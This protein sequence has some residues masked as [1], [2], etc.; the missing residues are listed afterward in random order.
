MKSIINQKYFSTA[1]EIMGNKSY[2]VVFKIS[3]EGIDLE[4]SSD[5]NVEV[6]IIKIPKK[7]FIKYEVEKDEAFS[8]DSK[9]ILSII[10]KYPDENIDMTTDES[11]INLIITKNRR[12]REYNRR[13]M[14]VK[15]EKDAIVENVKEKLKTMKFDN[16]LKIKTKELKEMLDDLTLS[17]TSIQIEIVK[18]KLFIKE[19]NETK[20]KSKTETNL[21]TFFKNSKVSVNK[22]RLYKIIE[23]L[24][25]SIETI[26]V[27]TST[28][29]PLIIKSTEGINLTYLLAPLIDNT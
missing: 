20:G 13:L 19:E 18:N 23:P 14:E 25:K 9:D 17:T 8:I 6:I 16:V 10:K 5:D 28:D 3:K 4:F 21:L 12:K 11:Y 2:E 1:T 24:S 15:Q 27:S 7:E 26:E 29:N 22:D